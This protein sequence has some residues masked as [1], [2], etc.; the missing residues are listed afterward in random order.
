MLWRC[1]S[2]LPELFPNRA[3][4][5]ALVAACLNHGMRSTPIVGIGELVDKGRY[6]QLVYEPC[7]HTLALA[8]FADRDPVEQ[9]RRGHATCVECEFQRRY[10]GR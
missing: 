5:V 4:T 2:I 3:A 1:F 6:W 7:G 10:A 8:D 9:V